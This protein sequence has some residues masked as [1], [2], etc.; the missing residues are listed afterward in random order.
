MRK[1]VSV[2]AR[3][4]C[5]F[6]CLAGLY[7]LTRFGLYTN[8][9]TVFDTV[10]ANCAVVLAGLV[11]YAIYKTCCGCWGARRGVQ[12]KV[13][14]LA[15]AP[16]GGYVDFEQR[17]TEVV[18]G[19]PRLTLQNVWILV[20]GVGFIL[21][22][23][24]YTL[25]GQHPLCLACFGFAVSVLAVDE[26]ICP[27]VSLSK[28]YASARSAGLLCS[29]VSLVLV[30]AEE[31]SVML[32]AVVETLDF[33]SLC[34]GFFLPFV[35]QFLLVAVRESRHYSLGSIFEVVEFGLPFAAFLSVFHLCVAYGQQFQQDKGTRPVGQ[36]VSMDLDIAPGLACLYAVGPFLLGP[37]LL[38]YFHCALQGMA[39]DVLVSVNA[40]LCAH[41]LLNYSGSVLGI[42]G[43]VCCVVA[44]FVRVAS[45]YE[46]LL[47]APAVH[48]PQLPGEGADVVAWERQ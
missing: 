1:H 17:P 18:W 11:Y 16:D 31:V 30:T 40:V 43:T 25:L 39:I 13:M 44:A 42:Y 29:V 41:Y 23:G 7:V 32:T 20:Y 9:V 3:L 47:E 10:C 24:G 33:Y 48:A 6:V 38:A 36:P 19:V 2:A 21:F 8:S 22:V 26:L 4:G 15:R 34:F 14:L 35:A 28:V 46:F 27:R 45:E 5:M 37:V 12:R